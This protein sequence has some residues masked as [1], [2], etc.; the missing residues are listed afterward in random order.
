MIN[1]LLKY[2][3]KKFPIILNEI[4]KENQ[5][6]QSLLLNNFYVYSNLLL[7]PLNNKSKFSLN[8][9]AKIYQ[10]NS[11]I[12]LFKISSNNDLNTFK[13]YLDNTLENP[14][15]L[16][17]FPF[18]NLKTKNEKFIDVILSYN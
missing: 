1:K 11:L 7:E 17:N 2:V 16:N 5:I 8:Y 14:D 3:F 13:T 6:N 9:T 15:L 10:N 18:K 4:Y 12:K